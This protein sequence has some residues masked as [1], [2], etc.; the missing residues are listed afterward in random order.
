MKIQG[1]TVEEWEA[2]LAEANRLTKRP[3]Q[4]SV[5]AMLAGPV[6][7]RSAP[8]GPVEAYAHYRTLKGDAQFKFYVQNTDAVWAGY[9]KH[10]AA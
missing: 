4:I 8:L 2:M 6:P 3:A 1:H 7:T 5:T 10:L 9:Q